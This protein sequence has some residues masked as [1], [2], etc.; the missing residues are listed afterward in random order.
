M[1]ILESA[2]DYLEQILL[3]KKEKG[4]V[5]SIDIANSMSFSKASVSIAMKKLKEKELISISDKGLID[6]T[7]KGE[8]IAKY[9][10][11]KHILI[12]EAL[13]KIGVSES[14]AYVD[15]C[16][17]EHEISDETFL[18]IKKYFEK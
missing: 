7:S 17:I 6:L 2:E 10:Y 9:T 18:A 8:E 13:K 3:L 11:E 4:L 12:F 15:A 5:R 14:N 1:N 16:K